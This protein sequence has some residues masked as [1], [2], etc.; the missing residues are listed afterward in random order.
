MP[1]PE[2]K[3]RG[4][5]LRRLGT[6]MSRRKEDKKAADRPPSP[7]KR[8]RPHF[9]LRRGTSSK[10]MQTIPSPDEETM[11]MPKS[12]PQRETENAQPTRSQNVAVPPTPPQQRRTN[13][14]VNGDAIEPAPTR[15]STLPV[16]NG[17]QTDTTP[18]DEEPPHVPATQTSEA[19][20][21]Q[22]CSCTHD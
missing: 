15:S 1:S 16:V 7:E 8:S 2:K 21:T 18:V 13:G 6:V 20:E 14:R 3:P 9:A 10:N 4:F 5:G 12:P 19:S 17:I 11:P 22:H